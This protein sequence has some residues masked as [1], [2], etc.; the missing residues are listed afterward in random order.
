MKQFIRTIALIALV[1]LFCSCALAETTPFEALLAQRQEIDRQLI[2]AGGFGPFPIAQGDFEIGVDLPAG[3]YAVETSVLTAIS[4]YETAPAEGVEPI[5]ACTVKQKEPLQEL[6]LSEG[7][8]LV[9]SGSQTTF[10]LVA[11]ENTENAPTEAFYETLKAM[12]QAIDAQMTADASYV[13]LK[14]A[15]ATYTVGVDLPAGVY[16]TDNPPM[17]VVAIYNGNPSQDE[18]LAVMYTI[19]S[20]EPVEKFTLEEGQTLVIDGMKEIEISTYIGLKF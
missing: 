7:N 12:R 3:T 11:A 17:C 4:V 18:N 19:T 5:F 1:A 20:H 2:A 13:D 15:H 16:C 14:T 10:T 6:V 9:M 8:V